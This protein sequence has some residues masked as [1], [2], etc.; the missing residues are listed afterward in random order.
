MQANAQGKAKVQM[1]RLSPA[2]RAS[3]RPAED[4]Y[5]YTAVEMKI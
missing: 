3:S 5:R 1:R 2:R 4:F